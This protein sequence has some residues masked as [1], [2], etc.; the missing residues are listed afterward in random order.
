MRQ[1]RLGDAS[2][3]LCQ[4]FSQAGVKCGI[5]GGYAIAVLGGARTRKDID[6]LA[7]VSKEEV[8]SILD[9]K[10]SFFLFLNPV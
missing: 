4:V 8:L 6:Y 1:V 2:I 10:N 5:F 7:S 3:A 9:G